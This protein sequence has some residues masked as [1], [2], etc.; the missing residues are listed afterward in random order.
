MGII[1]GLSESK[2]TL[3]SLGLETNGIGEHIDSS[4]EIEI[5]QELCFSFEQL[6][7][8]KSVTL[9][10]NFFDQKVAEMFLAMLEK[11][12]TMQVFTIPHTLPKEIVDKFE[13]LLS[14][15]SGGKKKKASKSSKKSKKKK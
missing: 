9:H 13:S 14:K 3:N 12:P 1:A 5:L 10:G 11:K 2:N 6:T 4:I 7:N 15:N 8:L